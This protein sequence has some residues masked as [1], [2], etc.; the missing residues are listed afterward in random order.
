MIGQPGPF[1][2]HDARL[3][4][5]QR[6]ANAAAALAALGRWEAARR[7]LERLTQPDSAAAI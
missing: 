3:A 2:D 7:L 4:F 5:Q 1:I 6:Q